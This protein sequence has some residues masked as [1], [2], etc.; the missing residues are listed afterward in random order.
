MNESVATDTLEPSDS[1][2]QRPAFGRLVAHAL[3]NVLLGIALGIGIYY[4]A[5]DAVS[6]LQQKS[7]RDS[8]DSL[9]AIASPAPDR[10]LPGPAESPFDFEGWESEDAAYWHALERGGVFGR[11]L[12]ERMELDVVVV[13][14][15]QRDVLK[16]GP[17]WVDY[18]DYPGPT[19]N[20]GVS[21]HRTTYGAP[22]GRLDELEV[23]DTI[24]LYSP[25][26][27]YRYEV[28]TKFR[29]TPDRV[30]VLDHTEEPLL[31]LT[32]CDP[33][34]SARLRLIVQAKLI[35]A[36]RLEDAGQE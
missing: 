15:H 28:T 34:Y 31:T 35:E 26:R 12:I 29:V 32:A 7:L 21:G 4:L 24:D 22:F 25:F 13:K 5:T 30:D 6:W 19:G 1:G 20:C 10:L 9:G 23:G 17:G 2:I 18:T 14:G 36:R 27:R 8:M 11:L 16:S 3:G 33:P